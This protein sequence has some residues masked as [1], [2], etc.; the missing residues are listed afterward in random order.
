MNGV[1]ILWSQIDKGRRGEN[2]GISTGIP[3]LDKVIGGVQPQRYY[4]ISAQSSA[5]KSSLLQFIMYNIL[6]NKTDGH[7]VHFLI[8]SLEIPESV[9]LAKLMGLYCA[10]EFGIYLTLDD[11][12]SFQTPLNDYAYECLKSAKK[13]I[14]SVENSLYIV[15][16]MCNC[17]TIYHET[18][19]FAERYGKFEENNGRKIYIPNNPK[20]L[21]IGVIDHGLL[22]Q[23]TEGRG[24]K[25]EI[26]LTSSYMVTLKN[27]LNMS[28]F[29]LM[30]QN[31]DSTSMDRRKA[32][33]SEPGLNDI[34]S[35]G[36]VG[37][38][39][40]VVIQLF[41]PFREK[42]ASYRG[43][44]ILGDYGLGRYHRSI[45]ISKQRY[46]VAD[47]VININFFGSVGWWKCLPDPE[48]ISDY[49]KF[50]TEVGNIPCKKRTEIKETKDDSTSKQVENKQPIIFNF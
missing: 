22:L 7:D 17:K 15:D 44:K 14:N 50:R 47:Q 49:A 23:P 6:K 40:D 36:N 29:M 41:Y 27:K 19:L 2:I 45:I 18:L 12:M 4:C 26:D 32:D 11:I 37:Q 24:I 30:Q 43:Y 34:K 16:K 21:L 46:G 33:L 5:G 48:E 39:S 20:Q 1:D 3:K 8:F 9:L 35:T 38:D 13:W 31:R 42:L 28:W 25:E 10:E